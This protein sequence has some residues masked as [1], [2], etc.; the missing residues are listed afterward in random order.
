MDADF[1]KTALLLTISMTFFISLLCGFHISHSLANSMC[2]LSPSFGLSNFSSCS[3]FFFPL[4]PFFQFIQRTF[5]IIV[6]NIYYL[7]Y[8]YL[9]LVKTSIIVVY[10]WALVFFS[11]SK[12]PTWLQALGWPTSVQFSFISATVESH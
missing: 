12:F 7:S 11:H 8:L 5:L 2:L 6:F 1:S 3:T 10:K 4:Y 9:M